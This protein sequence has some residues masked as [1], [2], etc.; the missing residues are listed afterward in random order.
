MQ[1][2]QDTFANDERK[3]QEK[4]ERVNQA[5]VYEVVERDRCTALSSKKFVTNQNLIL[6]N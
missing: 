2:L 5:S 6:F 1:A 4:R 3:M